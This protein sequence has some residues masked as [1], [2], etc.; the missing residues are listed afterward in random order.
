[1][2]IFYTLLKIFY[3]QSLIFICVKINVDFL[4]PFAMVFRTLSACLMAIS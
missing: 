3:V 1:M 4:R 2:V